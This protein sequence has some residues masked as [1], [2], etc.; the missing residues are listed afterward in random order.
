MKRF[1]HILVDLKKQNYFCTRGM[2][3]Q[4]Q[5]KKLTNLSVGAISQGLKVLQNRKLVEVSPLERNKNGKKLPSI[6]R[7]RSLSF[8]GMNRIQSLF[9]TIIEWKP[10]FQEMK[11]NLKN[12]EGDLE[13]LKGYSE[14]REFIE[15]LIKI[16]PTY[17]NVTKFFKS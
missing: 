15:N 5:I 4:S 12:N 1:F 14:I 7:I 10:I 11:E 16:T 17:E 13:N 9:G 2:L 3:T 8:A 6:Y